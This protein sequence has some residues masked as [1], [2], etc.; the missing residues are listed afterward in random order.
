MSDLLDQAKALYPEAFGL[1]APAEPES[2]IANAQFHLDW[3][4]KTIN[5]GLT[6]VN[7]YELKASLLQDLDAADLNLRKALM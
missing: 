4:R 3:V 7:D 6:G 2:Y 5:D 1:V